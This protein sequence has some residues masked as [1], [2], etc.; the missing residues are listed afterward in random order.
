MGS[1]LVHLPAGEAVAPSLGRRHQTGDEAFPAGI[2]PVG[3]ATRIPGARRRLLQMAIELA[4]QPVEGGDGQLGLAVMRAAGDGV[5]QQVHQR[6]ATIPDP[7]AEHDVIV[8]A[9]E[10]RGDLTHRMPSCR[11]I[12]SIS[13]DLRAQ[14]TL[15]MR[16]TG[17][18]TLASDRKSTRLN[19]SHVKI[20]YA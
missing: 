4:A 19:S 18:R 11:S 14:M 16:K 10:Q 2:D 20:S 1:C 5:A 12:H 13:V 17:M 3:E 6:L 7:V 9:D 15:P 8:G